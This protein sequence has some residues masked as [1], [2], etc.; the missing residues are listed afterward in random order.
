MQKLYL[1]FLNLKNALLSVF[2]TLDKE[3][4]AEC[5]SLTLDKDLLCRVSKKTLG[6]DNFKS[7]FDAL[8]KIKSK[9]F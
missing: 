7:N 9:S 6:I 1:N 8:N 5:F 3:A 4:F 2:F